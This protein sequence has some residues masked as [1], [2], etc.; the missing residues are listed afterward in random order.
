MADNES[1]SPQL[2]YV[3]E[4]DLE[5]FEE[6]TIGGYHPITLGDT[7]QDGRYQVVHQLGFGSYSTIWLA[8]DKRS[9]RYVSLK[10]LVASEASKSTE[11]AI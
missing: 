9:E 3:P 6:Y 10:V 4:V 11:G 8:R 5:G 2:V 1:Q 7:F